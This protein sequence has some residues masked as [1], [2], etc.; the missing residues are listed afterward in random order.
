MD[1]INK[2]WPA[3]HEVELIGRGAFGQV[4]KVRREEL[5]EVFYSAVKVISIPQDESEVQEMLEEGHTSQSVR[6][7]F[8]SVVKGLMNEIKV[9]EIL[10]SAT[11]IVNIED[12]FVQEKQDGIGWEAY[13]RMELL[14][15]LD[16]YRKSHVMAET[17]VVKLGID[18]CN[19]LEY[20]QKSKIVH[21]DIKPKNIF[22]DQYGNYK[23]GDFGIARQMEKT[24]STMSRKGTDAYIAPEV[25][26]GDSNSSYNVDVYSLG[27]VMYRLLNRNRLPFEPVEK[28]FISYQEKEEALA[29]RLKGEPL[30]LPVEADETLGRIIVKACEFSK[31]KRYKSAEE[32]KEALLQWQ[33]S[34]SDSEPEPVL[35]PKPEKK[36]EASR[37]DFS[38][39][40]EDMEKTRAAFEETKPEGNQE[41]P[42]EKQETKKEQETLPP[43]EGNDI[44]TTV[45]LSREKIVPG[46]KLEVYVP[47]LRRK[48]SVSVPGSARKEEYQ[49]CIPGE[50][51]PG[52]NGGRNGSLHLTL[53]VKEQKNMHTSHSEKTNR[54][55][56]EDSEEER[57]KMRRKLYVLLGINIVCSCLWLPLLEVTDIKTFLI[58]TIR[59]SPLPL[60]LGIY[61]SW[62]HYKRIGTLLVGVG[63]F[64]CAGMILCYSFEFI[65]SSYGS[66]PDIFLVIGCFGVFGIAIWAGL[67]AYVIA[68]EGGS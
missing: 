27:V 15:N 66:V 42:W 26:F 46:T 4:Y 37:V 35:E 57:V 31:K 29:R 40:K 55:N 65:L 24:Q 19:A 28:E 6:Y 20:C 30:P 21:R 64:C 52:K 41:K 13:I 53:H 54:K 61:L 56:K 39:S 62:K 16:A 17:D 25:R 23:L 22:V 11:N 44:W 67:H 32:M 51:E 14:E 12:F 59:D 33:K 9:L 47:E 45:F 34:E 63:S 60:G 7:Y 10:K 3:W 48:I 58:A 49:F 36:S 68:E 2:I 50:G 5:G 18:L 38:S 43:E 1:K 8:E